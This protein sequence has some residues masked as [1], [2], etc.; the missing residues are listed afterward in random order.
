MTN[1][2]KARITLENMDENGVAWSLEQALE[3][4][5]GRRTIKDLEENK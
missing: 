2:E 5:E 3:I 4:V 1:E